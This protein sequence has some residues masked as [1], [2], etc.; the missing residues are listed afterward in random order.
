MIYV[1]NKQKAYGKQ[2]L[3]EGVLHQGDRVLIVEDIINFGT[4]S[5]ANVHTVR[6]MGGIVTTCVSIGNYEQKEAQDQFKKSNVSLFAMITVR[7]VIEIAHAL[8]LIS[9]TEFESTIDWLREPK[10]W[11]ERQGK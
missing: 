11:L 3:V 7:E 6:D 9:K 5:L 2:N 4:S 8:Q 10:G 1:R